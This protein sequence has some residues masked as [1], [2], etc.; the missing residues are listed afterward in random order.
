[1]RDERPEIFWACEKWPLCKGGRKMKKN[2]RRISSSGTFVVALLFVLGVLI[3]AL[4]PAIA[5]EQG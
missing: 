2:G 1:M 5:S 4:T 3:T